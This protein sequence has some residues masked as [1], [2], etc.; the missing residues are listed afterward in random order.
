MSDSKIV[1]I[2]YSGHG[3]V[4]ADAALE[5]GLSLSGYTEL[6]KKSKNPFNLSY[7]GSEEELLNDDK[8]EVK[9]KYILGIGNN[10]IREKIAALII[11]KGRELVSIIHPT[12]IISKTASL[13]KGIFVSANVSINALVKIGQNCI[14]NTGSIL[15][16]ECEILDNVHIAPGAV[17][18]GNVKVGRNSFIGANTVVKQGVTIG[19][20]VVIGAGTVVISDV[21]DNKT[22][23]GN[24]V[25]EI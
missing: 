20:N 10:E 18:A 11:S 21:L 4:V 23:V 6:T 1:L 12:A 24:P 8:L 5:A 19:N 14:I 13:G 15:E 7:L 16:H 22:I 2:G 17:L 3:L 9:Y 25:R